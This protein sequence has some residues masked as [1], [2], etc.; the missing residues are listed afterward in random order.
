MCPHPSVSRYWNGSK[1][2]VKGRLHPC[3][4]TRPKVMIFFLLRHQHYS[5]GKSYVVSPM[6]WLTHLI[7]KVASKGI[8]QR[9]RRVLAFPGTVYLPAKQGFNHISL[10][11]NPFNLLELRHLPVNK[12][13]TSCTA[14]FGLLHFYKLHTTSTHAGTSG[15]NKV[16]VF[17][18]TQEKT[19]T[20]QG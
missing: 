2:R 14:E 4:L 20:Y 10:W 17:V 7:L 16:P 11:Q 8:L 9:H 3:S 6:L 12:S 13:C 1:G 15:Q 18:C 5:E 19:Q